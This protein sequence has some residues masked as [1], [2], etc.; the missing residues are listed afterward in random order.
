MTLFDRF[1]AWIRSSPFFYR[2]TLFTRVLLAAGFIPTGMVKLMGERFTILGPDTPIGAFFEAMYQTGLYWRFLGLSQVAA[3]CLLLVPRWAHLGAAVFVPIILNIFVVTVSLAFTGTPFVTGAMLLAAC[4]L[5]FW[6]FHRFRP[7]LTREPLAHEVAEHRLDRW[8]TLGFVV[9]ALSL[10]NFF[11]IIRSLY[12][13][14]LA[15]V[16]L[17]AGFVAGVFTLGRFLWLRQ[18]G[19]LAP[20]FD[21]REAA[22]AIGAP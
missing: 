2:F 4:Y 20:R 14:D 16:S 11:G 12:R 6:D 10:I 22:R 1:F 17:V 13:A 9:F 8:E 21:S 3:A 15:R 19:R 7:L 18:R 5:C